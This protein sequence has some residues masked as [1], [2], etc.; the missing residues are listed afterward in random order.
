MI[1]YPLIFIHIHI[2][3]HIS[4]YTYIYK[5]I[6]TYVYIIYLFNQIPDISGDPIS[7]PG[8]HMC[9]HLALMTIR[10]VKNKGETSIL[11]Q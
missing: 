11:V 10:L 9:D 4:I 6:Y 5:Y 7:I 1:N 8:D 3:M 2:Y